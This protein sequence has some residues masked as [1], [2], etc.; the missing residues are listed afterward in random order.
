[1]S[2]LEKYVQRIRQVTREARSEGSLQVSLEPLL[3]EL[4]RHFGVAYRPSVNETLKSLGISQTDST[5]PDSLFGHVVLDYKAPR[6]LSSPKELSGAKEQIEGYLDSASGGP[7]REESLLWAGIL[8]DGASLCF[9][10]S[11]GHGWVWTPI[12]EAS[13]SSLLTLIGTY[14][15][16]QRKPL[17]AQQLANSFGKIPKSRAT[18]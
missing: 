18:F 11:D 15:A 2:L 5:R 12:F 10:H 3:V 9:C 7:V 1:M 8:W 17:T 6:L 13:E 4:L 14:R 16:L